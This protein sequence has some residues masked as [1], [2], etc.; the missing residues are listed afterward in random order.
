MEA[1]LQALN[2]KKHKQPII[3]KDGSFLLT[4]QQI[5]PSFFF[6]HFFILFILANKEMILCW[7]LVLLHYL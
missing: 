6:T 2:A 7:Y 1:Q 4:G 3:C 5:L